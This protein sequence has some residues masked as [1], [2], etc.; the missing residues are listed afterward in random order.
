MSKNNLEKTIARLSRLTASQLG[1]LN[2]ILD[3]FERPI[4]SHRLSTSDVVNKEFLIA[5][6]DV[7]K[8]HHSMSQDYLDKHRFEA[9]IERV[10]NA[11]GRTASLPDNRCNPGHDLTVDGE[12]WSLKTQGDKGIKRDTLYISKF[13]ELGIGAWGNEKDLAGLRDQ[14]LRHM[15][16]YKR[17]FQLRY[18]RLK[19]TN[20][21][22]IEHYYELVEIPKKLL[23]EAK[24]GD[25]TMMHNSSQIPKPGYCTVTGRDGQSRF[26]LYFDGGTERKLQIKA[27]RKDLCVV[28][29]SWEF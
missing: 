23:A 25:I 17:I 26:K 27:L 10:Y 3:T 9:A 18:F 2:G 4:A 13:M 6:G 7:L 19:S 29:A 16:A 20:L 24:R 14:F 11:I 5:F 21:S 12:A 1:L 28:H 22:P 8:L 15:R